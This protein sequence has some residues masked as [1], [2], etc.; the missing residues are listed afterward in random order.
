MSRSTPPS[1]LPNRLGN[2]ALLILIAALITLPGVFGSPVLKI[3]ITTMLINLILVV[4]L[5]VFVGNSGVFSFG[6]VAFMAMGAY[7]VGIARIPA[8]VKAALFPRMPELQLDPVTAIVAGGLVAG[9]V[10]LIIGPALMR[11]TGLVAGLA[12]FALLNIVYIVS[13]NW[14]SITGGSTGLNGVPQTTTPIVALAWTAVAIVIAW[15]FRHTST[16]L[17]LR[18]TREDEVAARSLGIGVMRQRTAAFVISAFIAG[19]AGGLYAQFFG[20]FNSEAFFLKTTF[21][22]VAMLV[23]G[24]ARSLT[25]AVIGTL[26]VTLISEVLRRVESG[27]EVG[28]WSLSFRP[29]L[30]QLGVAVAMLA[31]LLFFPSG[32]TKG[33]EWSLLALRRTQAEEAS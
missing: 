12:T 14:H 17:Q 7:T 9:L 30:Q 1:L 20:T 10:A 3:I 15:L 33:R 8:N 16:A 32:L 22:I 27:V 24:G 28:S 21:A 19:I 11:L 2:L 25:G 4:A 31:V 26:F 6:H 29:G 23:I 5:Q 13:A 18:A